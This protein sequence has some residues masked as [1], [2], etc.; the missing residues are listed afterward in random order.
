LDWTFKNDRHGGAVY[1]GGRHRHR[2][3]PRP[4]GFWAATNDALEQV[5]RGI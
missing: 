5:G 3:L 4:R 2:R 1:T